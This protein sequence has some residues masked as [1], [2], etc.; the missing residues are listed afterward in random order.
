MGDG[1]VPGVQA[2]RLLVMRLMQG[3]ETER[4]RMIE[5]LQAHGVP[6]S[7]ATKVVGRAYGLGWRDGVLICEAPT[8]VWP[9]FSPL[10]LDHLN[11]PHAPRP[12]PD[13]DS[14]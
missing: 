1:D 3:S 2:D 12:R 14:P 11:A 4:K 13:R 5:V 10:S 9:D 6:L 8:P 7:E